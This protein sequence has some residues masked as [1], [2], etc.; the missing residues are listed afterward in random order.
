MDGQSG[1]HPGRTLRAAAAVVLFVAAAAAW[2]ILSTAPALNV[3]ARVPRPEAS[4]RHITPGALY[5]AGRNYREQGW[6]HL[7]A[8]LAA[9]APDGAPGDAV[10]NTSPETAR[11]LFESSVARSPGDAM[12]WAGLALSAALEGDQTTYAI[13]MEQSGA[14]APYSRGISRMR[15]IALGLVSDAAPTQAVAL[16]LRRDFRM[17]A[18]ALDD[19]TRRLILERYTFLAPAAPAPAPSLIP[20]D[21][22]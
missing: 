16:V 6:A 21:S 2:D 9:A 22:P 17:A 13:A 12:A 5:D 4:W 19:D 3:E 11:R 8:L 18:E 15:L 20:A 7:G 1:G 14:L 10:V